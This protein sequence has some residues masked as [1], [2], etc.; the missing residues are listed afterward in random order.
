VGKAR[1]LID[2]KT[3]FADGSIIQVRIWTVPKAVPPSQ[4]GYKYSLFFGRAGERL[5]GFDNE[6]GKGDHYHVRGIERPY[7]FVSIAQLLQDFRR[8]TEAVKGGSL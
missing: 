8:E 3:V 1:L 2:D 7:C 4:H 5:V 6:R